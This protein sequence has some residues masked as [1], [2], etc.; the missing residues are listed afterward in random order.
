[1]WVGLLVEYHDLYAEYFDCLRIGVSVRF[2]AT[3][4]EQ[5]I[6]YFVKLGLVGLLERLPAQDQFLYL[7]YDHLVLG[8]L[9]LEATPN[10]ASGSARGET[11]W[12]QSLLVQEPDMV[13]AIPS[14]A[15]LHYNNSRCSVR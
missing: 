6:N 13:D 14:N 5:G 2:F 7:D 4:F 12:L 8:R 15:R 10:T 3:E 11:V 1:M 9:Q